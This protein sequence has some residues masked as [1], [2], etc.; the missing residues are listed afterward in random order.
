M[1][2][3]WVAPFSFAGDGP[4]HDVEIG[5]SFWTGDRANTL[6][7]TSQTTQGGFTFLSFA[8]VHHHRTTAWRT[9]AMQLRQVGRMNA[10]AGEINAPIDHKYGVRSEFVWKHSPLSEETIAS[11]GTGTIIR[12]ART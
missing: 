6:A 2:R 7:P 11:N 1:G 5:G 10:A 8:P 12:A 3:A 9:R 4:L